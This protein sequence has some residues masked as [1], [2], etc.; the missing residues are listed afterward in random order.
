MRVLICYQNKTSNIPFLKGH[1]EEVI[2]KR[3]LM[4]GEDGELF[5]II[6]DD[7]RGDETEWETTLRN[8]RLERTDE[9]KW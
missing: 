1:S 9:L 8:D 7:S 4:K 2:R 3:S 6:G 5:V